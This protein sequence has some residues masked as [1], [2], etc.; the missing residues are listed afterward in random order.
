MSENHV[1]TI[2]IDKITSQIN[3][4]TL[5]TAISPIF[6]AYRATGKGQEEALR[7]AL[8]DLAWLEKEIQGISQRHEKEI[9]RK[10]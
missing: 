4:Q 6:A 7:A 5:T 3:P 10:S 8:L 1:R 2:V 9:P